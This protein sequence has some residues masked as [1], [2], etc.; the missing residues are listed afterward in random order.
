TG[1][2]ETARLSLQAMQILETVAQYGNPNSITDAGVGAQMAYVGAVGSVYNVLINL[3]DIED[4]QFDKQISQQC[5]DILQKAGN[6]HMIVQKIVY[7]KIEKLRLS[8]E[9]SFS[10][11]I[12]L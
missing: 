10:S 2:S 6:A 1:L 5:A 3:K 4:E 11:S 7:E 12:N 8:Q 9:I